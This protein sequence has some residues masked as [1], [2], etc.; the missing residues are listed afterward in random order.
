MLEAYL[1]LTPKNETTVARRL[2]RSHD[3]TNLSK[4]SAMNHVSDRHPLP[5]VPSYV[6]SS[7]HYEWCMNS[8]RL[9]VDSFVAELTNRSGHCTVIDVGMNDGFYTMLS[10]AMGCKVYAFEVQQMCVE[11]AYDFVARNHFEDTVHIFHQPVSAH[12][13]E[14]MAIPHFEACDGGFSFSGGFANATT[15]TR[16]G[17][18]NLPVRAKSVLRAIALD[19]FV[20]SG[21]VVDILKIDTEGHEPHVLQG[22]LGL[23]KSRAIRQTWLEVQRE[24]TGRAW[25]SYAV[26]QQILSWGYVAQFVGKWA[27]P[28]GTFKAADWPA[29]HQ[30]LSARARG[31]VD[32]LLSLLEDESAVHRKATSL[33]SNQSAVL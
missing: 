29:F 25:R 4:V 28:H 33:E 23:Y 27:C 26:L 9:Q 32:L 15:G 3:V 19:T 12:N 11:I 14:A 5:G 2:A 31:C 18:L 16:I 17:H 8:E 1:A 6:T 22:A 13:G 24:G 7:V 10:A 30:H 20:H 21:T